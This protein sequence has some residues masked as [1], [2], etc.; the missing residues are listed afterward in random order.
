MSARK[1]LGWNISRLLRGSREFLFLYPSMAPCVQGNNRLSIIPVCL[2]IPRDNSDASIK[3]A[4]ATP[5]F[6][7]KST[8]RS[9]A[10]S[11]SRRF[12][13]LQKKDHHDTPLTN[14]NSKPL[15]PT[16]RR[17]LLGTTT[18]CQ[19]PNNSRD[20]LRIRSDHQQGLWIDVKT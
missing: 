5:R 16:I 9:T 17:R 4:M 13:S 6:P 20:G 2:D 3:T 15:L 19:I 10:T 8:S 11:S 7:T 12:H 18:D 14:L 1:N